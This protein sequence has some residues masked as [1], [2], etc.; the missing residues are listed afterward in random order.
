[1]C[2]EANKT[3]IYNLLILMINHIL[4]EEEENMQKII[5][6]KLNNPEFI[7][8]LEIDSQST[9]QDLSFFS[10]MLLNYINK[11]NSSF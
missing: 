11:I 7:N 4:N 2:N 9:N 8:N 5:F 3:Y 10:Q 6:Q 1:M